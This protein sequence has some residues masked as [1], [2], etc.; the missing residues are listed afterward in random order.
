MSE[1][2]GEES[3][4]V[5]VGG[6]G[7]GRTSSSSAYTVRLSCCK[8]RRLAAR[9]CSSFDLLGFWGL[10]AATGTL[11]GVCG[12]GSDGSLGG[13]IVLAGIFGPV[14]FLRAF[15]EELEELLELVTVSPELLSG[16]LT[17][18]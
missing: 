11:F 16:H 12:G 8:P 17:R 15:G 1:L 4:L 9:C 18:R 6:S 5:T 2:E 10:F 13:V 14:S 7:L 3:T